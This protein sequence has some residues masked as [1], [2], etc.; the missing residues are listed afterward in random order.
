MVMSFETA[1]TRER[2]VGMNESNHPVIG[3]RAHF[4]AELDS[5]GRWR[6]DSDQ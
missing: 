3:V 2:I 1:F 5:L 6:I 4:F